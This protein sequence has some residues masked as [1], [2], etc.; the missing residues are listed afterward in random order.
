MKLKRLVIHNIASIADAVIDFEGPEL[1]DEAVFLICGETGSGKTM[2]LDSICLA[3]YNDT[4]RLAQASRNDSYMDQ[5]GMTV[6]LTNPVQYLR[7]GTWE[8][9][10]ELRFE[11]GGLEYAASWS[12]RRANRKSDG[13]FQNIVWEVLDIKSGMTSKGSSIAEII[14]LDFDEFRRTVMLAQGDFTA[15]L[16]S[17]DDEK[18]A[19]LEKITGTGIYR[20]MGR[21]IAVHYKDVADAYARR[22]EAMQAAKAGMLEDEEEA[23]LKKQMEEEMRAVKSK[24]TER[25]NTDRLRNAYAEKDTAEAEK[26]RNAELIEDAYGEYARLS[27]GIRFAEEALAA[28]ETELKVMLDFINGNSLHS[29][30]FSESTVIV[31]DLI[32]IKRDRTGAALLAKE[33]AGLAASVGQFEEDLAAK[34]DKAKSCEAAYKAQEAVLASLTARRKEL[35]RDALRKE[36][37]AIEAVTRLKETEEKA[38][39][40]VNAAAAKLNELSGLSED[41]KNAFTAADELW[42]STEEIYE[43]LKESN[44]QWARDARAGLKPGGKC[45]VCGQTIASQAYLDSISDSHFESMLKPVKERLKQQ[46]DARDNALK[47]MMKNDAEIDSMSSVLAQK[48]KELAEIRNNLAAFTSSGIGPD[49]SEEH[50]IYVAKRL[51]D[52]EVLVKEIESESMKLNTMHKSII[53]TGA[54]VSSAASALQEC[55]RRI[56]DATKAARDAEEHAEAILC[57][58]DE[59]IS[60][61]GWKDGWEDAPDDFIS[62]LRQEAGHYMK[63]LSEISRLEG[64]IGKIREGLSAI[65][66]VR[67]AVKALSAGFSETVPGPAVKTEG[68]LECWTSLQGRVNGMLAGMKAAQERIQT[69]N[70]VIDGLMEEGYAG[71]PEEL[72]KRSLELSEEIMSLN[73]SIGSAS[74]MLEVNAAGRERIAKEAASIEKI[75]LELERWKA[76]NEVFGKKDGEYFQKIAQGFIMNDILGRSNHYLG[77]MTRRYVLESRQGSLGILVRDMEQGGIP[78]STSTISGGESFVISLAL[79]LGLSSLGSGS[80]SVDTLFIDEG[81]GTLSEE[82]L[83]TVIETLQKLHETG[84]KKVGIISHVKILQERIATRIAVTKT[85]PVTSRVEVCCG[86]NQKR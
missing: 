2:I 79:A 5:A 35:D 84:G 46:K 26:A 70:D 28:R 52:A 4:P 78:R 72:E 71:S 38:D 42:R 20:L 19:I 65:S 64:N 62:R 77:K 85:D 44:E 63:T 41:L 13:R 59:L 55:R 81:F 27:G 48:E 14:G 24:E 86:Q 57:E 50:Y 23:R 16:K 31:K 7:K 1:R 39:K 61:E 60:W 69:Q 43:S 33:A 34:T 8:A 67:D 25:L 15:F 9:S 6:T 83:N 12:I 11:S 68:L 30:M 29:R 22:Q 66:S 76:L 47:A 32:E 49:C 80:I 58:V 45:P 17:R 10:I 54:E 18:S 82:Y 73:R 74:R 53:S 37:E 56:E 75:R 51:E 3:L 40:A 21:R 36:K